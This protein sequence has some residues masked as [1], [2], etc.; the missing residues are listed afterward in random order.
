MSVDWPWLSMC[1]FWPL[2][3]VLGVLIFKKPWSIK[4]WAILITA[5]EWVCCLMVIVG[6]DTSLPGWQFIEDYAWIQSFNIRFQLAVDGLSVWLVLANAWLNLMVM[7]NNWSAQYKNLRTYYALLLLFEALSMGILLADDLMLFFFFWE[8]SL[9]PVMLLIAQFGIGAQSRQAATQY[10]LMMLLSGV[11]LLIGIACLEIRYLAEHAGEFSF[12]LQSLATLHLTESEQYGLLVLWLLAFAIKAP[13]PPFHNWLPLVALNAPPSL[14]ALL[15]GMKLG[16]FGMIRLLIPLVPQA[17]MH[18]QEILAVWAMV[19]VLYAGVIAIRQTNLRA[20]LA[21]SSVS[22]VA[23]VFM[24]LLA[25]N[26]QA[27]QGAGL[28]ML[29]FALI[30]A[31]LMLMAGMLEKRFA[32]NDLTHL[33]GLAKPLPKFTLVFFGL[34]FAS[35]GLPGTSGFIAEAMLLLGVAKT[36]PVMLGVM[37]LGSF[38]A[39]IYSVSFLKKA[40][41]GPVRHQALFLSDDLKLHETILLIAVMVLIVIFGLLPDIVLSFQAPGLEFLLSSIART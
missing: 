22:H 39:A 25:F 3:G 11:V 21:Y 9:V 20:L 31:S 24:A 5:L 37:L 38:V 32:S 29:N 35:L 6:F 36:F 30:S 28:Q 7:I 4:V 33:G 17:L 27:W 10:T 41:W 16:L 23:L 34:I 18:F 2:L 1:L 40:F 14:T 26:Q 8:L 12:S 13:L 19:S 15:F